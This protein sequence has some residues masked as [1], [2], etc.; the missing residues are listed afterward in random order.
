[1]VIAVLD[2]NE[3]LLPAT[4][5]VYFPGIALEP[6]T[7]FS[8]ELAE[9][10]DGGVT[11]FLVKVVVTPVI[12]GETLNVTAELKVLKDVT[13]IVELLELSVCILSE[14]GA[15]EI[16]KYGCVGCIPTLGF[17]NASMKSGFSRIPNVT[18]AIMA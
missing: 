18:S 1:M 6:T 14:F 2:T 3:P 11:G 7:I 15:A 13:V 10:P 17:A 12:E 16:E 4:V 5:K 8:V 9:S